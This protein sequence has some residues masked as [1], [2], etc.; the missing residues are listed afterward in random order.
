MFIKRL[1]MR[2]LL[3]FPGDMEPVDLDPLNVLIGPNGSGKS[4][5][6]EVLEL[7]RATST[8]FAGAIRDGGGASEWL[9]KGDGSTTSAR[10]DIETGGSDSGLETPT[11]RPLRYKLE[12]TSSN[13]RVEVLDEAIEEKDP[14]P[15]HDEPYF[16]YRFQ[17]GRPVLNIRE[18]ESNLD[19]GATSN[20]VYERIQRNLKRDAL[21]PDESVL[22]QRKDPDLYPEV[23]WIG[24]KFAQIQTF[25]DWTF[26][27][28]SP[29]R[30][31]QPADLQESGLL[32]DSRNLAL[33]LNQLEHRSPQRFNDLL[34]RFF[35]RF[36]RVST[37]ISGGSVQFYLHEADL[38]SAIPATRLS[39]G[40]MRFIAMLAILLAPE[41]PPI[42][43]IEEPELGL[44]P[45]AVALVGEL[46]IEA[47]QRMQLIVTTHSDALVSAL[48][49]VS[50]SVIAC[51][52]PGMGTTMRRLDPER[53]HHWLDDYR[54]G[55]LWR[56]GELGANP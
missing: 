4:N 52:R 22:S 27:R 8:G 12:F 49:D 5:V 55:D 46:L 24:K 34:K 13:S 51:E 40:T 18:I 2:G 53:L 56:L 28:Y 11:T 14:L 26:G 36:E 47:S 38:R 37:M 30:Q 7:L 15:G 35:P 48:T 41:P 31:P 50:Q 9:W 1:E 54:L 21:R 3:S 6:I 19:E 45:D 17:G 42:A 23:T 20:R 44:H 33:L 29:L 43:C 32:P 10:I 25:R 39:D 16:Y